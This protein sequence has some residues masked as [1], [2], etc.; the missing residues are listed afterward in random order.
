MAIPVR[1]ALRWTDPPQRNASAWA[2]AEVEA[3]RAHRWPY[4]VHHL[5]SHLTAEERPAV[6]AARLG[7]FPWL[8]ARLRLAGIKGLLGDFALAAPGPVLGRLERA[9]RHGAHVLSHGEGWPGL[10]APGTALG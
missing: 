9:L 4:L 5:A 6:L 2:L 8:D 1:G 7:E 3:D 10:P